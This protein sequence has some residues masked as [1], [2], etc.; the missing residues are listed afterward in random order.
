MRKLRIDDAPGKELIAPIRAGNTDALRAFIA[1]RL[2]WNR[3][4]LVHDRLVTYSIFHD[5]NLRA[6]DGKVAALLFD[7]LLGTL[8]G[9]LSAAEFAAWL[10]LFD[11]L[12]SKATRDIDSAQCKSIRQAL[13]GAEERAAS[14]GGNI[15][16]WF[17]RLRRF[18]LFKEVSLESF[19]EY[20]GGDD[21]PAECK[22]LI[23]ESFEGTLRLE[24]RLLYAGAVHWIWRGDRCPNSE[25][26][27]PM[28]LRAIVRDKDGRCQCYGYQAPAECP[29]PAQAIVKRIEGTTF[30]IGW[31]FELD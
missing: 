9:E 15:A 25:H 3:H 22:T 14:E 6:L 18:I 27:V 19:Q 31:L 10:L 20:Q 5:I 8:S 12:R 16:F 24:K 13:A 26:W 29:V 17:H 11:S 21:F 1:A 7:Y 28:Q 4:P 2:A 23:E 30:Q